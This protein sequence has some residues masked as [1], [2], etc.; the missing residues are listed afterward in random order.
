M[1]KTR[2][3][4]LENVSRSL[5]LNDSDP[6]RLVGLLVNELLNAKLHGIQLNAISNHL[7]IGAVRKIS[8]ISLSSA[9]LS[10]YKRSVIDLT[11]AVAEKMSIQVCEL[12]KCKITSSNQRLTI[13]PMDDGPISAF[14]ILLEQNISPSVVHSQYGIWKTN[15]G[16]NVGDRRNWA[17]P[18]LIEK[19]KKH[20]VIPSVP[21]SHSRPTQLRRLLKTMPDLIDEADSEATFD[22]PFGSLLDKKILDFCNLEVQQKKKR[23]CPWLQQVPNL[24]P[25][26]FV[27]EVEAKDRLT[28][29]LYCR[30]IKDT[31][32]KVGKD[33]NSGGSRFKKKDKGIVIRMKREDDEILRECETLLLNQ[34]SSRGIYPLSDTYEQFAVSYINLCN[35][36]LDICSLTPALRSRIIAITA[37]K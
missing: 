18:E 23:N 10:V 7:I 34:L 22:E 31:A 2:Y 26:K 3:S 13:A 11:A 17:Q 25:F 16:W 9:N 29:Y 24:P 14:I 19:L 32:A 35:V 33:H 37:T 15:F 6:E 12:V 20:N 8:N 28:P 30:R 36:V 4:K 5:K 27:E 21:I 1:G